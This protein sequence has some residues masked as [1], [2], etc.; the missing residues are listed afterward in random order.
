M[1]P[2][3]VSPS[4]RNVIVCSL[5]LSPPHEK[6]VSERIFLKVPDVPFV[7]YIKK[8]DFIKSL[9]KRIVY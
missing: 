7:I 4:V 8:K 9:I 3:N 1:I 5:L 6:K 2:A